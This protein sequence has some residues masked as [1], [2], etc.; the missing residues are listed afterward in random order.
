MIPLN[1]DSI[2]TETW[3]GIQR[4][5]LRRPTRDRINKKRR[6]C[7]RDFDGHYQL[8]YTIKVTQYPVGI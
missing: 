4:I 6:N 5:G 1:V 2:L 3:G 7:E 8:R